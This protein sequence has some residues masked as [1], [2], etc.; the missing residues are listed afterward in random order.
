MKLLKRSES[1]DLSI[2]DIWVGVFLFVLFAVSNIQ[3]QGGYIGDEVFHMYRF[4][5]FFEELRNGRLPFYYNYTCMGY[6]YGSPFFYGHILFYFYTPIYLIFGLGSFVPICHL[7]VLFGSYFFSR[8]LFK[9]LRVCNERFGAILYTTGT[10]FVM[11]FL[12]NTML[13]C[14]VAQ[15][16]G[17]LFICYCIDFFRDGKHILRSVVIFA[18]IVGTH[19]ITSVIMVVCAITICIYYFRWS[20][21]KSY[22]LY[23]AFHALVSLYFACNLLYHYKVDFEVGSLNGIISESNTN[24]HL[25]NHIVGLDFDGYFTICSIGTFIL[26]SVLF[27]ERLRKKKVSRKELVLAVGLVMG[28]V[29]SVSAVFKPLLGQTFLQFSFRYMPYLV[30]LFYALALREEITKKWIKVTVIVESV[31][32]SFVIIFSL[33]I[34]DWDRAL[35]DMNIDSSYLYI[36]N[37]EYLTSLDIGVTNHLTEGIGVAYVNGEPVQGDLGIRGQRGTEYQRCCALNYDLRGIAP[38]DTISS[39]GV[40]SIEGD[41]HIGD[42]VVFPKFHYNGYQCNAGEVYEGEYDLCEVICD[43]DCVQIELKYKHPIWLVIVDCISVFCA[44]FA[45]M[46]SYTPLGRKAGLVDV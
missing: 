25:S 18:L 19:T 8:M 9:R 7:F 22:F 36:G 6:G 41:F 23:L 16:L 2:A 38:V 3:H 43:K 17:L 44:L 11:T 21:V 10:Y 24:Y 27:I 37:G 14:A 29:L 15:T 33:N 30:V 32:L 46:L 39:T 45:F 26:C 35:S 40:F 34:S 13:A 20:R 28:V 5:Y 1:I 4:L 12:C 42:R 31:I